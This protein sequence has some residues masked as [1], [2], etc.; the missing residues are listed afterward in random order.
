MKQVRFRI[1]II[2]A[3]LTVLTAL[4]SGYAK[5]I[6]YARDFFNEANQLIDSVTNAAQKEEVEKVGTLTADEAWKEMEKL[7]KAFY[8]KSGIECS[9]TVKVIDDNGEKEKIIEE[10]QFQYSLLDQ[11]NYQYRMGGLE[12]VSRSKFIISADHENKTIAISRKN[13]FSPGSNIFD[14]RA[15]REIVEQKKVNALVTQLGEEKVITI[16]SIPDENIQGYRIYYSPETYRINKMLV[17]MVRLTP[18]E[19]EEEDVNTPVEEGEVPEYYYYLEVSFDTVNKL[20]LNERSFQPERKF[21]RIS[22]GK[23]E[24]APEASGYQLLNTIAL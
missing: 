22:D 20:S 2:L 7:V 6:F 18:L 4:M 19:N 15:F 14:V 8:P 10:Q 17:G 3:I 23:I 21:I 12:I 11:D 9:G 13:R 24:L 16:D 1:L 5:S